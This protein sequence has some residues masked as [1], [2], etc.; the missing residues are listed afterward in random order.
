MATAVVALN[1]LPIILFLLQQQY[2]ENAVIF[3]SNIYK[4]IANKMNKS[5]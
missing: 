3:V 1:Q 4:N 5:A 2:W